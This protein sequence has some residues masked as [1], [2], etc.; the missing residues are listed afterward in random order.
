MSTSLQNALVAIKR[1]I[2]EKHERDSQI[3]DPRLEEKIFQLDL[4]IT[5]AEEHANVGDLDVVANL[6]Q[7]I[8]PEAR[9]GEVVESE[10]WFRIALLQ[11]QLGQSQQAIGTLSLAEAQ[12]DWYLQN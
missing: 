7:R 10:F 2:R 9:K 1:H 5:T 12:V 3:G 8:L 6:L 4:D 11:A